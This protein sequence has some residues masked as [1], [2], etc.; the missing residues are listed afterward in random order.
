MARTN[1][2][3]GQTT[4][5]N[6]VLI[7]LC[8]IGVILAIFFFRGTI[9]DAFRGSSSEAEAPFRP[10]TVQCDPNY[11]GACVPSPPPRIT[12]ADLVAS[13]VSVPFAVTGSDPQ[14]LDPDGDG[15]ACN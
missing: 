14:N 6:A 9:A 3:K 5:E 8:G 1:G 13:G 15:L 12:C 4:A 2:E 11:S 7:A 10:P